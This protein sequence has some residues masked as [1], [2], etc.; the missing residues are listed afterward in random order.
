[1]SSGAG[2]PEFVTSSSSLELKCEATL[3]AISLSH[4]VSHLTLPERR[5]Q[6]ETDG[7]KV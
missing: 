1:M 2:L 6:K 3:R 4:L 7:A 5:L